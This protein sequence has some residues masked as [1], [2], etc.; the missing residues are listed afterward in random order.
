MARKCVHVRNE[1]D[2]TLAPGDVSIFDCGRFVGQVRASIGTKVVLLLVLTQRSA[3]TKVVW[4][5]KQYW[6]K[7]SIGTRVLAP[8]C[9]HDSSG[10]TRLDLAIAVVARQ[11]CWHDSSGGIEV[12]IRCDCGFR[13]VARRSSRRCYLAMT[14]SCHMARTRACTSDADGQPTYR[15]YRMFDSMFDRMFD[16]VSTRMTECPIECSTECSMECSM[17]TVQTTKV[18]LIA[19]SAGTLNGN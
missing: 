18:E 9:W 17:Q 11:W 4:A 5:Q 1:S 12:S 16:R 10:G 8:K 14:S 19:D 2:I 15:F 7:S 3:G 6:R 13:W